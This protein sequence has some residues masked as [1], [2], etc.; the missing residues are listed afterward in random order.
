MCIVYRNVV[1]EKI[2]DAVAPKKK[3]NRVINEKQAL[4]AVKTLIEWAGDD[5]KREGLIDTPKRVVKAYAEFFAGYNEDP[6]KILAKTFDDVKGY[7]D[8]VMLKNIDFQSHCEHHM[9][10]IV[11][12]VHIAYIPKK[13][14]VGI[15]KIARVVDVFAKRLQTQETMTQQI[16]KSI[17]NYLKPKGVAVV[18]DAFHQCMTTR[19]VNKP[20]VSTITNSFIG[21]FKSNAQHREKFYAYLNKN[22][23][24]V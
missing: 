6:E 7:D 22:D 12:R 4:E 9:V 10:P 23:N 17:Q 24:I 18:I 8:I 21:E 16:S 3:K 15:S 1:K 20:N 11:G 13:R 14:V 19:G 2:M 5:P